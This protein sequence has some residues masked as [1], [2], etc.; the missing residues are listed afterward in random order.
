[1]SHA[2]TMVVISQS[3]GCPKGLAS[4]CNQQRLTNANAY[5]VTSGEYGVVM[6]VPIP[7]PPLHPHLPPLSP[8][9]LATTVAALVS[10]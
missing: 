1:M 6:H 3:E 5:Q 8:T 10:L 2:H 9:L 4:C 7:Y